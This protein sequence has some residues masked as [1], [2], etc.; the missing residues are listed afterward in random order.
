MKQKSSALKILQTHY[1]TVYLK[2][3]IIAALSYL[4]HFMEKFELIAAKYCELI[5]LTVDP[6]TLYSAVNEIP[7]F[8]PIAGIADK[9]GLITDAFTAIT[10]RT[11]LASTKAD[12]L[13]M[14]AALTFAQ[15]NDY[16]L[17]NTLK[18]VQMF[19]EYLVFIFEGVYPENYEDVQGEFDNVFT[20]IY[21]RNLNM[22]DKD[23][24]ALIE[25]VETAFCN[26]YDGICHNAFIEITGSA[27]DGDNK[28]KLKT[29]LPDSI[30]TI[31]Q[32]KKYLTDLHNNGEDYHPDGSAEDCLDVNKP[33]AKQMDKLMDQ[34]CGLQ[35]NDFDACGFLLDL[36]SKLMEEVKN[37]LNP[38]LK[39]K[40]AK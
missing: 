18:N 23:E 34:V 32:A 19:V 22:D 9:P 39:S 10:G 24:L 31:E 2:G 33:T 21:G 8:C 17:F 27:Y 26:P 12:S 7:G 3:C 15:A 16:F 30:T 37:E 6:E 35:N 4:K 25:S 14:D 13:L 29:E 38:E 20:Y 40:P 11:Y 5:K 1:R 28:R 36:Q